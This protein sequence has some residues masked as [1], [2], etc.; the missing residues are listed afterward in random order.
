MQRTFVRGAAGL[1]VTLAAALAVACAQPTTTTGT[2]PATPVAVTPTT[3]AP[4]TVETAVPKTVETAVP[5]TAAPQPPAQPTGRLI[6]GVS[7]LR[8][9][10]DP[11]TTLGS[12]VTPHFR[13]IF[14]G[15]TS[16]DAEGNINAR[17]A[18][19]WRVLPDNS[20]WE[21]KIRPGM[22]F[23]NGDPVTG[24][25]VKW[26]FDWI[27]NPENRSAYLA[28][29]NGQAVS[30]VV[31][32]DPMTVVLQ[33]S[34]PAPILPRVV[35]NMN[36]TSPRLFEEGGVR[37]W[38]TQE[39]G[40][41]PYTVKS[42]T[43]DQNIV[44]EPARAANP[45]RPNAAKLQEVVFRVIPEA[46][47]RQAAFRTNEIDLVGGLEIDQLDA[48]VREGA[49]LFSTE[50]NYTLLLN[51]NPFVDSPVQNPMVR[52]AVSLGMNRE[53]IVQGVY[54][55]QAKAANQIVPP[56]ANGYD[57]SIPPA[58]YNLQQ[59]RQMLAQA[60]FANGFTSRMHVLN[61]SAPFVSTGQAVQG[62]LEE[63]GIRVEIE[64]VGGTAYQTLFNNG[65]F[66]PFAVNNYTSVNQDGD[67]A[68]TWFLSNAPEGRLRYQN[69]NFDRALNASK[70][71]MDPARRTQLLREAGRILA[72]EDPV[73]AYLVWQQTS[74]AAK[75]KVFN[76]TPLPANFDLD[77]T[78]VTQ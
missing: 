13:A 11:L 44:L 69:P 64:L 63:M 62:Y 7:G 19:S 32:T 18:E 39:A 34:R 55:G 54:N 50:V 67:P 25:A 38:T 73:S 77:G 9:D 57:P 75:P 27:R 47:T 51:M 4:K 26:T 16:V 37:A 60:G 24:E 43:P 15:L 65:T 61:S 59:A 68:L 31:L 5:K 1:A 78:F 28:N 33:T 70:V 21:F 46:S 29:L 66:H 36:I 58:T 52:R 45:A 6:I 20:G 23:H 49:K 40:T 17:V 71:E 76:F 72:S 74:Y 56:I 41:G 30:G 2:T 8:N 53:E 35:A 42:F 14:D 48:L 3:A 10:L 22:T 12:G